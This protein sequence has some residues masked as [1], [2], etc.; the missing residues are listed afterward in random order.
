M[1]PV[2]FCSEDSAKLGQ[3]PVILHG[4][5]DRL[6]QNR[7]ESRGWRGFA[8]GVAQAFG[9]SRGKASRCVLRGTPGC[10][11]VRAKLPILRDE[12]LENAPPAKAGSPEGRAK[13][14]GFR[15]ID[16]AFRR[17]WAPNPTLPCP[18]AAARAE[19]HLAERD[20]YTSVDFQVFKERLRF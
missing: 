12:V 4:V 10:Y 3:S 11:N 17:V 19:I 9:A 1:V 8:L 5:L 6:V 14:R 15:A 13:L 7:R 20:V 2:P 18:G 16:V